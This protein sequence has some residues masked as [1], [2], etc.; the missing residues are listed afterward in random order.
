MMRIYKLR[1]FLA[2]FCFAV[3]V[4]ANAPMPFVWFVYLWFVIYA[5][6][7]IGPV[8]LWNM[9]RDTTRYL[10]DAVVSPLEAARF[11]RAG[12]V[13]GTYRISVP[14][15]MFHA[16]LRCAAGRRRPWYRRP[17]PLVIAALEASIW[18]DLDQELARA[19]SATRLLQSTAKLN[20]TFQKQLRDAERT[21]HWASRE[22]TKT[23]LNP[24]ARRRLREG[25]VITG[26]GMEQTPDGPKIVVSLSSESNS[27][28]VHNLP[29]LPVAE[30]W[31][32]QYAAEKELEQAWITYARTTFPTR[33]GRDKA[34]GDVQ[35][36]AERIGATRMYLESTYGPA[37][38]PAPPRAPSK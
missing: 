24:D 11:R 25:G 13:R 26:L 5:V 3:A 8:R 36:M 1:L 20:A 4:E 14:R 7:R 37:P 9:I 30:A 31:I 15:A 12:R 16:A 6:F 28:P 29:N 33:L 22:L 35:A 32:K 27:S 10:L 38:F 19:E 21:S 34:R 2:S 17:K 23:V 18:P